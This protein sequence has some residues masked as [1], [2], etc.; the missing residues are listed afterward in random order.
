M[1]APPSARPRIASELGRTQFRRGLSRIA[2]LKVAV[3]GE[4]IVDEYAY[5]DAIGKSGKEPMLV[6]RFL[7]CET[8]AGGVL[9]I[10]NHLADFCGHVEVVSALGDTERRES[11]VRG[12]LRQE[13]RATFI[14]KP[15]SPTI[16]KRRYIDALTQAKM[17]GVYRLNSE[18]LRDATE[19]CAVLERVLDRVDVAIVAD[20]GH[21]LLTD[22]TIAILAEKA[23][24]LALNTQLNADNHGYNVLSRYP[25]ANYACVHEGELRLDAREPYGP[26]EGVLARTLTRIGAQAVMVTRGKAGSMLYERG[27]NL[28]CCPALAEQVVERVGAGDAVLALSSVAVAAGLGGAMA[29]FLGNLA[30]AQAVAVVGN[31]AA[32]R[33]DELVR[34]GESLLPTEAPRLCIGG[35][36]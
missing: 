25:R 28:E 8:Q 15:H 32:I 33:K 9:A 31:S 21:G 17:M 22:P 6:T 10:A 24:F 16:V 1:L 14:T 26:L 12:A 29:S 36:V 27:G 11:F 7:R 34:R 20:Y 4:T 23:S 5:C 18:Q 13:V 30:G 2:E 3:I 35:G 19:L